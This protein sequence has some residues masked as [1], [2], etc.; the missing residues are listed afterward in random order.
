MFAAVLLVTTTTSVTLLSAPDAI[1]ANSS[2]HPAPDF[3]LP[4]LSGN[5]ALDD[6]RGQYLYVDFWA[7]WCGP[8]RQSFPWMNDMLDK[9]EAQGLKIVAI[10]LDEKRSDAMRFLD[11]VPTDVDIVFDSSGST[12]ESFKVRGMP[13][14]Y[15]INP[16]GQIIFSHIG[17]RKRESSKLEAEIVRLMG[18]S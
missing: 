5:K 8:C 1:A 4:S 11:E 2:K 14:S 13:S 3:S 12:A 7:S 18:S 9:Y 17:F 15:L 10:N 16:E 6:Y